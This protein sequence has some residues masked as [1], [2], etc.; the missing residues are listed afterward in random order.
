MDKGIKLFDKGRENNPDNYRLPLEEAFIY[1][2]NQKNYNKAAE[3]FEEASE[4]PGLSPF[5][6]A[7][8]KGMAASALNKGGNRNLSKEVWSIIYNT[9]PSES[10]S[11]FA[12]KNLDVL[13]TKDIEDELTKSLE[14]YI[15]THQELPKNIGVLL[16]LGF[17][18]KTPAA[19]VGGKY[20]IAPKIRAIRN[21]TV[22]KEEIRH[23]IG[24][25]NAKSQRFNTLN[26]RYVNDL[27]ELREYIQSNTTAD[28]PIHPLGEKYEYN[29]ETGKISSQLVLQ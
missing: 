8:I 21:S 20:F 29:P 16:D 15:E 7:S 25:L 17:I 9:S 2:L 22:A 24:F 10:R 12:K 14:Q 23:N 3:L 11:A 18:K 27:T 13:R 28:Y 5:R 4:K 1:Y 26:N 19:P 6:Q